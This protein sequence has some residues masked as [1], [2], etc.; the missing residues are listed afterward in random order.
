MQNRML[1]FLCVIALVSIAFGVSLTDAFWGIITFIIVSVLFVVILAL[2]SAP[3]IKFINW[4]FT[5]VPVQPPK[6]RPV[7]RPAKIVTN[8]EKSKASKI[9]WGFMATFLFYLVDCFILLGIWA[10]AGG[11]SDRIPTWALYTAPAIP[12]AVFYTIVGIR[13]LIIKKHAKRKAKRA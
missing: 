9:F 12:I 7:A 3:V 8:K 1:T 6:P 13:R 4:G 10:I 5:P 11:R 2:F